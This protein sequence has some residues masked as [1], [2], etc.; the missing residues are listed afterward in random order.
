MPVE[1]TARL[2]NIIDNSSGILEYGSGGSTIY[3][4]QSIADFI[5]TTENDQEF[6]NDVIAHYPK[7]G[8][9]LIANYVYVG[10]TGLWGYPLN[11]DHIDKWHRYPVVPWEAAE[12]NNLSPDTVI[13]DGR[14]RVACFLYSIGHAQRDTVIF[15]DDYVNR[16]SYHVVEEI[17]KPVATYGRAAVF[18]KKSEKFHKEMFDFYCQ[19]MR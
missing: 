12:E 7:G 19:D 10:E 3:A 5:I 1:E 11:R 8:P 14:F 18:E 6:L 9:K 4:G 16:E 13:I 2:K 15:W 17:V